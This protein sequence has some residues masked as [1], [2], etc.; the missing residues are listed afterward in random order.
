MRARSARLAICAAGLSL[1]LVSIP[2]RAASSLPE[3]LSVP[4][5]LPQSR[6]LVSWV[7]KQC[8]SVRSAREIARSLGRWDETSAGAFAWSQVESSLTRLR[9]L[10]PPTPVEAG[11]PGD[12]AAGALP[13]P[14]YPEELMELSRSVAAVAAACDSI[15]QKRPSREAL[16][17]LTS[18]LS[19]GRDVGWAGEF[20]R[21]TQAAGPDPSAIAALAQTITTQAAPLP[22]TDAVAP[23]AEQPAQSLIA[24]GLSELQRQGV[25][26]ALEQL[27]VEACH[28]PSR[29]LAAHLC[30][31]VEELAS[32]PIEQLPERLRRAARADL[33]ALPI[34]L[35]GSSP[36]AREVAAAV[37]LGLLVVRETSEGKAGYRI[38]AGLSALSCSDETRFVCESDV[39]VATRTSGATAM[40]VLAELRWLEKKQATLSGDESAAVLLGM[41]QWLREQKLTTRSPVDLEDV[42]DALAVLQALERARKID[43][44]S[45]APAVLAAQI[46]AILGLIARRLPEDAPARRALPAL[47][48]AL[49][50]LNSRNLVEVGAATH[51]LLVAIKMTPPAG[52]R[53]L[54]SLIVRLATIDSAESALEALANAPGVQETAASLMGYSSAPDGTF[55]DHPVRRRGVAGPR[56]GLAK[57]VAGVR[58]S[59]VYQHWVP[60]EIPDAHYETTGLNLL[61]LELLLNHDELKFLSWL[62]AHLKYEI[63]PGGDRDQEELLRVV[64]EE[65]SGWESIAGNLHAALPFLSS[66]DVLRGP[67]YSFQRRYFLS[68]AQALQDYWYYSGGT[69]RLLVPGDT[70]STATIFTRHRGGFRGTQLSPA[71]KPSWG[72][73]LGGYYVDYRKPYTH[74]RFAT[75]PGTAIFD[76]ELQGG[77]AYLEGSKYFNPFGGDQDAWKAVVAVYGGPA[78]IL[79][80]DVSAAAILPA[81]ST[82][83]MGE[84]EVAL[85]IPAVW[86]G[87]AYLGGK[88][89]LDYR[90]FG[91]W[92]AGGS[93][94]PAR[95]STQNL[96]NDLIF[97]LSVV[98][99]Y[100]L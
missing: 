34:H 49:S 40:T 73:E 37:A 56:T 78:S 76:A 21:R 47:E 91:D 63:R 48:Q 94:D 18:L 65:K 44:K 12:P 62:Q 60:R 43:D 79:L 14:L 30:A 96:N 19:E 53:D 7:A 68:S 28:G 24:Q 23:L 93:S 31:V 71:G 54:V 5:E 20:F 80:D 15:A 39:G 97:G 36:E 86:I 98:G 50:G 25:R 70:V 29:A 35:A 57:Y 81:E 27:G 90:T 52:S 9:S 64:A 32:Q 42:E 89:E 4:D 38:L 85:E 1:A 72:Y 33:A 61:R 16:L 26:K 10:T 11:E 77:G 99:G 69:V 100:F 59:Y 75:L 17:A 46:S 8:D 22:V 41:E 66:K 13:N 92:F 88:V 84:V 6:M 55:A 74:D 82:I 95:A 58:A 51:Q 87:G 2:A 83:F 67:A 45:G 3:P